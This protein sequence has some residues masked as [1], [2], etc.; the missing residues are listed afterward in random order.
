MRALRRCVNGP[1]HT[2]AMSAFPFTDLRDFLRQLER[3]GE[4]RR[5]SAPVDPY[6]E[7]TEI[8]QRVLR[9]Q[10]PALLFEHP[11]SGEMPLLINLFGTRRRME[12]ALGVS[13]FDE[14]GD[15]IASLLKP[16]LP[17]GWAGLREAFGK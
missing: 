1:D 7:V 10:G 3:S 13:D 16:E 6:L 12:A 14:I 2:G 8:V 15:R 9:E 5:V 11:T 4:L 17:V